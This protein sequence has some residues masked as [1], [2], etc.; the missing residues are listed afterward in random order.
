[1]EQDEASWPVWPLT[2]QEFLRGAKCLGFKPD[3]SQKVPES[4][5]NGQI[6]VHDKD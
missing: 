4:F 3:R 5:A 1:M 2:A 6:V